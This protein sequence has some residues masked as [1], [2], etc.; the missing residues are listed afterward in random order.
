MSEEAP[1]SALEKHIQT[2]IGVV[3]VAFAVWLATSVSEMQQDV[4][5]MQ[6]QMTNMAEKTADLK[7]GM[8]NRYTSSDAERDRAARDLAHER[9]EDELND[10][11]E[12]I[13][14]LER[15]R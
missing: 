13:E 5:R 10:L 9:F 6:V 4:A 1:R 15:A 3:L 7:I 14:K 8:A 12:R 11:E 2:G